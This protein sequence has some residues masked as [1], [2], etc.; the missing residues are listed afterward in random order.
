MKC[1][2]C[3]AEIVVSKVKGDDWFCYIA[4]C[5]D[6]N[7][8]INVNTCKNDE[9]GI[10]SNGTGDAFTEE[11]ALKAWEKYDKDIKSNFKEAI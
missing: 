9:L 7:V 11:G 1:L 6:C 8:F 2:A 10:F 4:G 3:G 5:P